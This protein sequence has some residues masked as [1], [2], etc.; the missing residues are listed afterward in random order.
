[1]VGRERALSPAGA[2]SPRVS[3][4]RRPAGRRRAAGGPWQTSA[5]RALTIARRSPGEAVWRPPLVGGRRR[6]HD[7]RQRSPVSRRDSSCYRVR[8]AADLQPA[9]GRSGP[10]LGRPAVSGHYRG[11]VGDLMRSRRAGAPFPRPAAPGTLAGTERPG[12]AMKPVSEAGGTGGSLAHNPP[13]EPRSPPSAD[14]VM[15]RSLRDPARLGVLGFTGPNPVAS[16]GA[17]LGGHRGCSSARKSATFA[18]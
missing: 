10:F 15:R 1:M 9:T 6:R 4:R 16:S 13:A 2:R 14:R 17:R 5:A 18:S 8:R 7:R 12:I 3:G 11:R